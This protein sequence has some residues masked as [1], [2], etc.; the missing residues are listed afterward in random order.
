MR[1]DRIRTWLLASRPKTLWAAFAPVLMGGALALDSGSFHPGVFA[2]CLLTSFVFQVG[3][4]FCNDIFDFIKGTDT[5]D[6]VGP[7]R[8]TQAGLITPGQMKW[9][10]GITFA[11]A[12]GLS[13]LLVIRGGWWIAAL[14]LSGVVSG[15]LY[16]AGPKP[17]G[18]VGL[19]D[20]FVLIY[21]GPV[22]TAGT[23]YLTAGE[24]VPFGV[25]VGLCPGLL[26]VGI[27]VMNN[28]R[29]LE[30]D[31]KAGKRTLA[32]RLGS[33]FTIRQY[34]VCLFGPHLIACLLVLMT[35][36]HAASL[37]VL[38]LLPASRK[39]VRYVATHPAPVD[40][41]PMLGATAKLLLSFS[42]L[43][44]LGWWIS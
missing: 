11:L 23:A 4:N 12:L 27:L 33:A 24:W 25:L 17:L 6:R 32:V 38:I 22:A 2:L 31:R 36:S 15:I 29:D 37:A 40:L 20:L 7:T 44:S 30:G 16:T 5:E 41:I 14:G 28:L 35:Q 42:L 43:W 21:F 8:A 1:S 9:A 3:T 26:S 39:A 10:T 34:A 19:G 18:Y 13:L